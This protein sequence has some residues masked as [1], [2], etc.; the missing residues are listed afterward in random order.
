MHQALAQIKNLFLKLWR[1]PLEQLFISG[2][3]EKMG[4]GYPYLSSILIGFSI[5]KHPFWGYPRLWKFPSHHGFQL[6]HLNFGAFDNNKWPGAAT[7]FP[8]SHSHKCC[9]EVHATSLP[10][11]LSSS[12]P[13]FTTDNPTSQWQGILLWFCFSRYLFIPQSIIAQ[14]WMKSF[15]YISQQN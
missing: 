11:E 8:T 5:I 15:L 6:E 10:I 9:L 1:R 7:W 2:V 13:Q 3:W 12:F 4:G 14:N